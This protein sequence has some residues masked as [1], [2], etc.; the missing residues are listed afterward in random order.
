MKLQRL[1]GL[2]LA[3]LLSGCGGD[4]GGAPSEYPTSGDPVP[5]LTEFVMEE[6]PEGEEE[7]EEPKVASFVS[8]EPGTAPDGTAG[9]VYHYTALPDG[10][11]SI[12][13]YVGALT[14]EEMGFVVV[15][16]HNGWET[17]FTF[18]ADADAIHI[19]KNPLEATTDTYLYIT[20]DGNTA[21]VLVYER[22]AVA[23]GEEALPL[24]PDPNNPEASSPPEALNFVMSL[25]PSL[26]GLDG[27]SMSKYE[28]YFQQGLVQVD[29]TPCMQLRV[30]EL[31]EPE[32][33]NV[34]RETY[35]LSA[36]LKLLF[37]LDRDS[38][39][40]E[41]ISLPEPDL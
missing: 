34:Y 25:A 5:A 11:N 14:A 24:I 2:A 13:Q 20:W 31:R 1:F 26:L 22:P 37:K 16:P 27:D 21:S 28:V 12:R 7:P 15:S 23:E 32:L 17:S 9:I 39:A 10:G 19:T 41:E 40:V 36:D 35:F 30:Y 4:E 29:D 6:V 33:T 38:G 18:S 8:S 3:L